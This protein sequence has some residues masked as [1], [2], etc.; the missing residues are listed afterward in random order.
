M[1]KNNPFRKGIALIVIILC[2]GT[3]IVIGAQGYIGISNNIGQNNGDNYIFLKDI[4]QQPIFHNGRIPQVYPISVN[5]A[6]QI[7][8]WYD[9]DAPSFGS[10]AVN[11][12]DGDD[13]L[14]IVFGTYFNDEHIYALNAESGTLLWKYNTGG[15]NDAS[16]AIA[17][18]DL[19]GELEVVVPASSPY[20]VYCF[21]GATGQV[22]WSTSTGYPN[23]I[24]SPPAVADVDNDDKP[25]VILGTFYG[26]VF[27]LN[28]EDGSICWQTNLGTDSYIQ[29]GPNVLDLNGDGQ[30]DIVVAQ[31]S[32]DYRIYALKG[33]DA[34]VLWF[35]DQPQDHMYHGGSFADIDEDGKPEIAIGCYD[36]HVYVVNGED[37]SPLWDYYATYYIGAP[38]S[39]ADLNNDGHLEIVFTS[40]NRLGVLSYTGSLLWSYTTG[41]SIFRG[42]A[43]TDIDDDGILDVVFGSDD[44]I[45]RVLQG[46]D[47]SEIWTYD[48]EAHYGQTYEMDHAP[49]IADFDNDGKLDVFIIGGYGTSSPPT[50]NHGRAYAIAAGEGTG[51]GWP[52]FRHDLRHSACLKENQPPDRPEI[53]GPTEGE[54]G[55]E[56]TFSTSTTDPDG[57]QVW[58]KWD[59]GDEITDWIGPFG[60]EVVVNESHIWTSPGVYMVKVKA[61]DSYD[62]ESDWSEP[63]SVII[64]QLAPELEIDI[65]GGIGIHIIIKNS[66]YENATEV[67]WSVSV[68][69]GILGL[70]NV[71]LESDT[72]L[73]EPEKEIH[74]KILLFRLGKIEIIVTA[75]ASNA[76]KVTKTENAIVLF[77]IC[78]L[79]P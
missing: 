64:I 37:G 12:I 5:N 8:W 14:E 35:S 1:A 10:A 77:A 28:G 61:K 33:D 9:L 24:D 71:S 76:E 73:L 6:P 63:L 50:D 42:V 4:D 54:L 43:I 78:I 30:L 29:S 13:N 15:C 47:G 60:S 49:V 39:I 38:T 65:K 48:L 44:G 52:M 79:I 40:Y 3:N 32:G 22:E 7:L 41:G 74:E 59:F 25:E 18:V 53:N 31:W 72:Q 70:I 75:D 20:R 46:N 27:C 19:D 68:K 56:L 23:C 17:D 55:E 51:P 58:Y 11:D 2:V 45:L 16:P 26:Y 57:D 69:G 21:N 67:E 62:Q 66:G 36:N 34:S